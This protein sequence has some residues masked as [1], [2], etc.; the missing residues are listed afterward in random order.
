MAKVKAVVFDFI[1]TLVDLVGYSLEESEEKM[2]RSLIENGCNFSRG[3]FFEAYGRAHDKYRDLRYGKLVEVTNAVWI[4]EAL[5][6]LGYMVT[7][8]DERVRKAVNVFFEDYLAALKLR[9][10]A[11]RMLQKLSETYQLGIVS[12]YTYAPLIYA[13]LRK[14]EINDFFSV[15][16][17]SEEVGWRK[18]STKIFQETLRKLH[19]KAQE[20][21]FVGDTPLEDIEGAKKVGMKTVFIPSQFNSLADMQKASLQ[22]DYIIEKLMD[23]FKI[24]AGNCTHL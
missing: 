17:V 13:G 23:I 15:V 10:Y 7:P 12:N 8:K 22:P 4:S 11:K 9:P 6:Q 24:L 20:A 16:A 2:F 5:N 21:L 14:L 19:L 1:G 18:P 3:E